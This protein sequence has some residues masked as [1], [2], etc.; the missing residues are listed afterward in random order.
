MISSANHHSNPSRQ[1]SIA[2]RDGVPWVILA[3]AA[4]AI[5]AISG[6]SETGRLGTAG[7]S[8]QVTFVGPCARPHRA[9]HLHL[10]S[11]VR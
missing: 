2:V 4:M 9:R 6:G 1:S 7:A 5:V 8:C 3:I 10:A 11:V